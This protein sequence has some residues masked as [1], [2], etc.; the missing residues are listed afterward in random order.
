MVHIDFE[1]LPLR[2]S[3]CIVPGFKAMP[4]STD[5]VFQSV[6]CRPERFRRFRNA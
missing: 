6:E 5:V 1:E 3:A 2:G 4:F